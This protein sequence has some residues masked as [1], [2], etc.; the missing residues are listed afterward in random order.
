[1][2]ARAVSAGA[3]LLSPAADKPWGYTGYFGDPDGHP[4]E[5]AYVPSLLLEGGMLATD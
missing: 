4:W 3:L 1:M 2:L 5:I